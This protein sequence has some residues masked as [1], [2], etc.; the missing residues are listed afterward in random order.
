[1]V[2][3]ATGTVAGTTLRQAQGRGYYPYGETRY[4]TGTLFTDRL[5]TGQQQLAGLGLYNYRARFYDP[6]SDPSGHMA[7]KCNADGDC[8][9]HTDA[10]R[11]HDAYQLAYDYGSYARPGT[12]EDFSAR[13]RSENRELRHG[14]A[15]F[16]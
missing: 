3:K 15:N 5:F 9:D 14:L 10:D 4:S 2:V 6:Y 8:G 12:A 1:V 16:P 11:S 7:S 13:A